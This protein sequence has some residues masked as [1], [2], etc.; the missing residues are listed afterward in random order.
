MNNEQHREDTKYLQWSDGMYVMN[1]AIL[2][3]ALSYP[4]KDEKK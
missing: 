2:I 1:A 4:L 3:S